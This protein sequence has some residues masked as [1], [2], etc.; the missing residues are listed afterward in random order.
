[1]PRSQSISPISPVLL[2]R[3]STADPPALVV[4]YGDT[5]STLAA[6]FV[7]AKLDVPVAHV[8]AGLQS[9]DRRMPKEITAS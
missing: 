3:D 7:A 6:T 9:F 8:E 5:N 1:M 2:E 4:V